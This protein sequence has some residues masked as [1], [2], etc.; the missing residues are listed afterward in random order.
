VNNKVAECLIGTVDLHD[1]VGD[2]ATSTDQGP[3]RAIAAARQRREVRIAGEQMSWKHSTVWRSGTSTTRNV[4][5]R[6]L[7]TGLT[8]LSVTATQTST[9]SI[10]PSKLNCKY[11]RI[12]YLQNVSRGP[13]KYTLFLGN[14]IYVYITCPKNGPL[15]SMTVTSSKSNR[16]SELVHYLVGWQR[17]SPSL[18]I[19][20]QD[21]C[22]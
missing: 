14:V 5:W 16:F 3:A 22:R 8:Q 2:L 7:L 9:E 4:V 10:W 12:E 15:K 6:C 21:M 19:S 20:R 18:I 1:V 17:P 11:P 13:I